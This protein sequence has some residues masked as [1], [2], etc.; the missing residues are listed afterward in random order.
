MSFYACTFYKNGLPA[1]HLMGD[2]CE[3][4]QLNYFFTKEMQW[5]V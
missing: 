3:E 4:S 1:L 2:N 5:L